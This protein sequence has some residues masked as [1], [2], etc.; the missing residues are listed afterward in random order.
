MRHLHEW[1]HSRRITRFF[2]HVSLTAQPFFQS[3]GFELEEEVGPV[4]RGI[5]LRNAVMSKALTAEST[6]RSR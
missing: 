6:L 5:E 3:F 2:A 1:A 4:I